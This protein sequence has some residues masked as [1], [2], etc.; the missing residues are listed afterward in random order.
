MEFLYVF[1][2]SKKKSQ[3]LAYLEDFY[4][5]NKTKKKSNFSEE[6]SILPGFY[7]YRIHFENEIYAQTLCFFLSFSLVKVKELLPIY[8]LCNDSQPRV[9]TQIKA[10]EDGGSR[11]HVSHTI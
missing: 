8:S 1:E 10:E 4:F 5:L 6:R 3:S 11:K 9:M 2:E 7:V